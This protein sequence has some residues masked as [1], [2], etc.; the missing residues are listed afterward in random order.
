MIEKLSNTQ[1]DQQLS[2]SSF[3]E[4][5]DLHN[6]KLEQVAVNDKQIKHLGEELAKI[7]VVIDTETKRIDEA[8]RVLFG[9]VTEN[10][11]N[12]EMEFMLMDKSIKYLNETVSRRQAASASQ[13]DKFERKLSSIEFDLTSQLHDA[14]QDVDQATAKSDEKLNQLSVRLDTKLGG[15]ELVLNDLSN[16]SAANKELGVKLQA[17]SGSN[18]KQ[19]SIYNSTISHIEKNQ[20]TFDDKMLAFEQAN[21][22]LNDDIEKIQVAVDSIE[23]DLARHV[24]NV[25]TLQNTVTQLSEAD[26]G[27]VLSSDFLADIDK[28]HNMIKISNNSVE[29]TISQ[30]QK[31]LIQLKQDQA[32]IDEKVKKDFDHLSKRAR[33]RMEKDSKGLELEFTVFQS[34][35]RNKLAAFRKQLEES[36]L[37]SVE[38]N[39]S[40]EKLRDEQLAMVAKDVTTQERTRKMELR[41]SELT[42]VLDAHEKSLKEFENRLQSNKNYSKTVAKTFSTDLRENIELIEDVKLQVNRN[43]MD[44]SETAQ[45]TNRLELKLHN[46]ISQN[47]DHLHSK[48]ESKIQSLQHTDAELTLKIADIRN[49]LSVE[50]QEFERIQTL[51]KIFKD[52]V[53]LKV[54][55]INATLLQNQLSQEDRLS[56]IK[57]KLQSQLI[58]VQENARDLETKL[59]KTANLD[60]L[61]NELERIEKKI[62]DS[63]EVLTNKLSASNVQLQS[64]VDNIEGEVNKQLESVNSRARDLEKNSEKLTSE[65]A[66]I[67]RKI[68]LLQIEDSGLKNEFSHFSID[69]SRRLKSDEES[70]AS[71]DET[72]KQSK[73][74]INLLRIG[75]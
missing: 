2:L 37:Q 75:D 18:S 20:R 14:I 24:T 38:T 58:T 30:L 68:R 29:S 12:S 61:K 10:N 31:D 7:A 34:D 71:H 69:I 54:K 4:A 43:S 65:Q 36:S 5:S 48:I 39:N 56:K 25:K 53:Q 15:V 55:Q 13:L 22:I 35:M 64:E 17:E 63:E 60:D 40:I 70:L 47:K 57:N 62:V 72:L 11:Q 45:T 44:L 3:E 66:D 73:L 8:A 50:Q 51:E 59:S 19:L 41:A 52:S 46:Y 9:T 67:E 33:E 6:L 42:A 23:N 27:K 74:Q 1:L 28:L 32:D 49:K 26:S 21:L 16:E